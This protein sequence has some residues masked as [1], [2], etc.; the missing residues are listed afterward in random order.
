MFYEKYMSRLDE[1]GK[2]LLGDDEKRE[3]LEEVKI[4]FQLNID[5]NE[6]VADVQ[7]E[8]PLSKL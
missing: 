7:Q 8:P 4:A 2:T 1:M 5:L 6:E 3:M